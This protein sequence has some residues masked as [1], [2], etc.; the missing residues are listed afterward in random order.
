MRFRVAISLILLVALG[1]TVGAAYWLR[2]PVACGGEP[3]PND[4]R[5]RAAIEAANQL[6]IGAGFSELRAG[7][8][9]QDAVQGS[10]RW[11]H[12]IEV[13]AD[14]CVSIRG[15]TTGCVNI[16]YAALSR[17][18]DAS[19]LVERTL[20][21]QASHFRHRFCA[22]AEPLILTVEAELVGSYDC[23]P[24]HAREGTLHWQV[25]HG[26]LADMS[27]GAEAGAEAWLADRRSEDELLAV[28]GRSE[29]S[30]GG[31]VLLPPTPATCH[32]LYRLANDRRSAVVRPR[33]AEG[34]PNCPPDNIEAAQPGAP[35]GDPVTYIDDRWHRVL[36]VVDRGG[37]DAGCVEVE[38]VRLM[39]GQRVDHVRRFVVDAADEELEALELLNDEGFAFVD[40]VCTAQGL[41]AYLVPPTDQAAY[42]IAV[43]HASAPEGAVAIPAPVPDEAFPTLGVPGPT[44]VGHIRRCESGDGAACVSAAR[45]YAGGLA[46]PPDSER[47]QELLE[48]GCEAGHPPACALRAA[49]LGP[50]P[51]GNA[52]FQRACELGHGVSC[53]VLGD[54]S[55]FAATSR[56]TMAVAQAHYLRACELGVETA[57]VNTRLLVSLNL[58]D[59]VETP[60]AESPAAP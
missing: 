31:A 45:A 38:V 59:A 54:R 1:T 26:R 36:A 30:P 43:R 41:V 13:G 49:G 14:E 10:A 47:A 46:I 27:D 51:E 19:V 39:R 8:S 23:S 32:A 48:H 22:V 58:V 9:G 40:R 60:T 12:T 5:F 7:S 17:A 53:A 15:A 35:P 52:R 21:Y 57:C 42:A 20:D 25:R 33:L 28:S 44:L 2:R 18:D 55:R 50:G 16:L 3:A 29:F 6:D 24:W 56:E 34:T 37:F 4:A 11:S